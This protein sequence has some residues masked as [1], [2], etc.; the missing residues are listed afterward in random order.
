MPTDIALLT[1][2]LVS[3]SKVTLSQLRREVG[4]EVYADLYRPAR[5]LLDRLV[6]AEDCPDFLTLPA[7]ELLP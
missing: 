2:S 7:Y 1:L 5:H 6:L 3:Y 4:E